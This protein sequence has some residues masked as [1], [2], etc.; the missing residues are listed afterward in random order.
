MKNQTRVAMVML[1]AAA[2]VTVSGCGNDSA[3][4]E[5]VT[6]WRSID[7]CSLVDSDQLAKISED[8]TSVQGQKS[9]D[10]MSTACNFKGTDISRPLRIHLQDLPPNM[11]ASPIQIRTIEVDGRTG[12]VT[13]E[14]GGRCT[15]RFKFD[16]VTLGVVVSPDRSKTDV[17]VGDDS[18]KSC[19]A[20]KPLI[21]AIVD[22]ANL[23]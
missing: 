16:G 11:P 15:V 14:S 22:K 1:A 19:D 6:D 5:P 2:V 17:A 3:D 20:Q 8:P 7:P 23:K 12:T 4:R 13:E 21:S 9:G 10:Q 18:N